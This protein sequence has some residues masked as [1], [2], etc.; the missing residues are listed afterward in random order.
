MAAVNGNAP[1]ALA[2]L[3]LGADVFKVDRNGASVLHRLYNADGGATSF[4]PL[5][6]ERVMRAADAQAQRA[7]GGSGPGA[8]ALRALRNGSGE[9]AEDMREAAQ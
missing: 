4:A 8:A 5:V 9:T 1:A 7:D 3:S 2:L 6:E